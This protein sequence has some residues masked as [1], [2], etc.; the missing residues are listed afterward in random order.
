M[1]RRELAETLHGPSAVVTA[2]SAIRV[3]GRINAGAVY[4]LLALSMDSIVSGIK[5]QF[6]MDHNHESPFQD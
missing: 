2:R 6:L 5:I 4:S 1:R 3:S